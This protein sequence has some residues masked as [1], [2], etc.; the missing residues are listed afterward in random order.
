MKASFS[1]SVVLLLA[2]AFCSLAADGGKP[3]FKPKSIRVLIVT[4]MDHPAH[5][6]RQTA[7]ALKAELEKDARIKAEVM[8]DPWALESTDLTPYRVVVLHFNTGAGGYPFKWKK[9][10]PDKSA[11]NRL[12]RFVEGGGGLMVIHFACGAFGDWP[13][14]R[15]LVGRVWDEKNTHD[16]R[17]PFQV[18]IVDKEHP[19][20]RG[21]ASFETDDELYICLTG[22]RPVHTLADARSK[23]TKRDHPMAFVFSYGKGRVFH[24][25]LGHDVRAIRSEGAAELIRRGCVWA[26]AGRR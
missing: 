22:E 14:Y 3:P 10:S 23:V 8:A 24:T 25:P 17:G 13:E 15:D 5:D 6:W 11:R 9:P 1:L 2:A 26:A 21:L 19:I 18:R 12:K 20:T 4:G 7:P 16:P